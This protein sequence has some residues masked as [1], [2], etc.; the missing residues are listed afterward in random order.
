MDAR[1]VDFRGR[2]KEPNMFRHLSIVGIAVLFSG[3][4]AVAQVTT[5]TISGIVQDATGAAVAGAEIAI[6]NVETGFSRNITSDP[7]GRYAAPDLPL[8][9]YQVQAQHLGVQTE[10]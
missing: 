4:L 9:S 8:G 5:G 3:H 6:R 1:A 10:V 7:G 2:G